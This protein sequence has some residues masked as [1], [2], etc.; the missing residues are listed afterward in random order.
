MEAEQQKPWLAREW[1]GIVLVTVAVC[2]VIHNSFI[3]PPVVRPVVPE[4]E[5]PWTPP[6]GQRIT[7]LT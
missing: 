2:L 3:D 7:E 1:P 4:A 6:F 5:S